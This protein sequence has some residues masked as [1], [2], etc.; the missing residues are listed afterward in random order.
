MLRGLEVKEQSVLGTEINLR[1]ERK[2]KHPKP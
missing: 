1:P 2:P